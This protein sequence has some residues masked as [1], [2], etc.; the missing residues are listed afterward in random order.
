MSRT[1]LSPVYRLVGVC[2]ASVLIGVG[3][4]AC[5]QATST[6]VSND[7]PRP[8]VRV[9]ALREPMSQYLGEVYNQV[10]LG[11]GYRVPADGVMLFDTDG[12]LGAAL[13]DGTIDIA[14]VSL[15]SMIEGVTSGAQVATNNSEINRSQLAGLLG[16]DFDV[17]EPSEAINGFVGV[18]TPQF[19]AQYGDSFAALD[20]AKVRVRW[21]GP[22]GCFDISEVQTTQNVHF[23]TCGASFVRRYNQIVSDTSTV[24]ESDEEALDAL[25]SKRIDVA[26]IRST[27][28]ALIAR[29]GTTARVIALA[30][31]SGIQ[32]IDA[33]TTVGTKTA[34]DRDLAPALDQ[35]TT[36]LTSESLLEIG[37]QLES[38]STA[39]DLARCTAHSLGLAPAPPKACLSSSAE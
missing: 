17:R 13:R 18:A 14:P 6:V 12:Q 3:L 16:A 21:G 20:A 22:E 8:L 2:I 1:L 28:P 37:E 31:A 36:N 4:S 24:V 9:G 5:G 27:N 38:G 39:L 29:P 19:V 15:A 10:V 32:P 34:L 35:V 26:I 11:L 7:V 33:V 25:D 30:D 23:A